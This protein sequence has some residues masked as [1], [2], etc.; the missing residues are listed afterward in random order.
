MLFFKLGLKISDV[1]VNPPINP[2]LSLVILFLALVILYHIEAGQT[3]K[4]PF[5]C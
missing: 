4:S 5:H 3:Q 1:L 2:D